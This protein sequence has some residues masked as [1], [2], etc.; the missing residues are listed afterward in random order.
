M[1]IPFLELAPTYLELKAEMDL[2]IGGVL[3]KGWY[4]LGDEV[5][6]FEGEFAGYLGAK[7]CI[8]VASG[9][10]ALILCLMAYDIGPGDE[11]IVPSNTY[12]ATALAVSR[13]G[14][15][16]RFVEP[17]PG[18]HNLD[19]ANLKAA[20]TK[21]TVAVIPVHLYGLSADMD[22]IN[23]LAL[24]HG[25]RVI[26]DS[27]QAHGAKYKGKRTGTLGDAAAFSFYPGKCLGAFG[28]GGA[29]TTNDDSIADKVR[30]LRNYGSQAKYYNNYQGLNSRLDELQAAIL[31][32]KLRYLDEWN[33]RRTA[34]AS[35]LTK[36]L[37]NLP[38]VALQV[39]PTWSESCW[40]LFVIRTAHRDRVQQA[41]QARG[42]GTMIHYPLPPYRQKA[43]ECLGLAKGA[44]PIADQLADE[45][46]SLPMG[47]HLLAGDWL[48]VL[49]DTLRG[50]L[51]VGV[52]A[53]SE[54]RASHARA[55]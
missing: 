7:H 47:P 11:V 17:D 34:L 10:D 31:R 37:Q 44:F 18:T 50:A 4:V 46:L 25:F 2:A 9:L 28:D 41:L 15:R 29:V 22:P 40:H 19:P 12:F 45:V 39:Q 24:K 51:A 20:I 8:G 48:G 32:V 36:L 3:T 27:A 6:G 42:I 33:G 16:L 13:V 14:A 23:A 35:V 53:D 52:E 30:A 54:E 43:Y 5:A 1:K 21:R 38:E 49:A 55:S 26:E